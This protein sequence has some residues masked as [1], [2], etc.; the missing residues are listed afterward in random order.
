MVYPS[1]AQGGHRG[2]SGSRFFALIRIDAKIK[3]TV[4]M[5]LFQME[6]VSSRTVPMFIKLY[7]TMKRMNYESQLRLY[8]VLLKKM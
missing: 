5:I 8:E 3:G 1:G 7:K 4:L 6:M 2:A